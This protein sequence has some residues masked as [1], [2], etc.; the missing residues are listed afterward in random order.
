M[1]PGKTIQLSGR[2]SSLTVASQDFVG[3]TGNWYLLQADGS[4]PASYTPV[5]TVADPT[6]DIRVWDFNTSADVSGTAG[7]FR[8]RTWIPY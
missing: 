3:Y 6:L 1:A 2:F 7:T 4:T 8:D 5:F